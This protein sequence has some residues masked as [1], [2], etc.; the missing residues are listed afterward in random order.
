MNAQVQKGFTLIELMIVVAIIGILAAIAIPAYQNYITESQATRAA[1][2]LSSVRT[3]VDLCVTQIDKCDNISLPQSSLFGAGESTPTAKTGTGTNLKTVNGTGIVVTVGTTGESSI[4]GTFGDG[5][6]TALNGKTLGWYKASQAKG[7]QWACGT[8]MKK[9]EGRDKFMPNDCQRTPE[10][11]QKRAAG[12]ETTA[13][14]D[15]KKPSGE[16]K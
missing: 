9:D 4:V 11:A 2:E 8:S 12:E 7:G 10:E 1:G 14:A 16:A 6:S 3:S 15:S 13:G 5:A